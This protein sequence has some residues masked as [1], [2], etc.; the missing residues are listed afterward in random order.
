[1]T[2][3]RRCSERD[4]CAKHSA[5]YLGISVKSFLRLVKDRRV[6][7]ISYEFGGRRFAVADLDAFREASRRP[8]REVVA[9][10]VML[11]AGRIRP[12]KIPMDQLV[13]E[14][15]ADVERKRRKAG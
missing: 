1:M 11:E 9:R 12:V 4:R 14:A 2:E 5:A 15:K 8:A 10:E 7:S 3:C 13:R 6:A